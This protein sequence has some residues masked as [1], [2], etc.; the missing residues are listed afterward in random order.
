MKSYWLLLALLPGTTLHALQ[1]T[2]PQAALEELATA[3]EPETIARHLPE[4]VQKSLNEQP[5]ATKR[6]MMQKLLEIKDS[7]LGGHTVRPARDQEGWEIIDEDGDV[8][9]SVK[10]ADVFFS[11]VNALLRLEVKVD[12]RDADLFFVNMHLE[13]DEWRLDDFGPWSKNDLNLAKLLHQPTQMEKNEAAALETLHQL[14][15]NL[16]QYMYASLNGR[17]SSGYPSTLDVL[18]EPIN[19]DSNNRSFNYQALDKSFAADPLIKDGYEFRYVRTSLSNGMPGNPG[20]FEL[21]ATPVE[22]NKTGSKNYL[23]EQNGIH[24]TTENRPASDEDPGPD[25]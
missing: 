16:R 13:D 10:V 19:T 11:G 4:P 24:V 17:L 8:S 15:Q 12:Q 18:T 14:G 5:K 20:S 9:G 1:G 7:Q 21:T 3:T 22:F 23:M 2:T 6:Q 25:D